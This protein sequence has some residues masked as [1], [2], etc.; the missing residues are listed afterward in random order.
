M[1]PRSSRSLL[2]RLA[3]VAVVVLLAG[4]VGVAVASASSVTPQAA[5]LPV[6][7]Y[8]SY[9]PQTHCSP[10]A[11]AGTT[12]LGQW[13]VRTYGGRFGGIGRSCA[14]HSTSEHKEGR[15]FDWMLDVRRPAD[16][17]RV[18]RFL[19]EAF[20]AGPSG[21]PAELARRMGIMYVIWNDRMY[22]AYRGFRAT[23]YVN[24]ACRSKRTCSKTLRHRDHVHISLTRAGA[25]ARTSWYVGRVRGATVPPAP[26]STPTPAPGPSPTG[27][28]DWHGDGPGDG[29]GDGSGDH[30]WSG[31]H[32]SP[33]GR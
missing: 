20:G 24:S 7:P 27:P 28:T 23:P 30:G 1:A 11:K 29:S 5:K 25:K 26:A 16:R 17:A 4:M 10:K 8:A 12:Y 22:A 31:H 19:K 6:E 18:K 13:L 33:G 9:Q 32:W 3:A 15:A 21:E 2:P 14:G